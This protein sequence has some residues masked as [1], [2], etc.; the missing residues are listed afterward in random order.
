MILYLFDVE[1]QE[2]IKLLN[3]DVNSINSYAAKK[4]VHPQLVKIFIQHNA[5]TIAIGN[6]INSIHDKKG[7]LIKFY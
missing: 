6:Q 1:K 5:E 4:N 2:I 7:Q 3:G